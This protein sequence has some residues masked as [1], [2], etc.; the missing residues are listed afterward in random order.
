[1]NNTV[2]VYASTHHGNTEK[3]V[4]AIA[5]EYPVD[6][7]NIA[8]DGTGD[9]SAYE[10]I[11]IAS[12]V[13]FGKYYPE[14]LAYLSEHLPEDKKVFF[15]HT[16]GK[17]EEKQCAAA[18]E[19]AGSRHCECLGVFCCKGYDTYGPFKLIGGL[20]RSHPDAEDIAAAKQFYAD[21]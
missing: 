17:P 14:M 8:A 3:L 1:M 19:T 16:A 7:V 2:I 11:G 10:R 5:A 15:I 21:L 6:L 13:A 4:Q 12:G 20:N 18:K 9:L